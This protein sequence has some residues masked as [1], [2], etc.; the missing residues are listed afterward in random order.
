MSK[1]FGGARTY[2]GTQARSL[3]GLP[4][5]S[6]ARLLLERLGT[7]DPATPRQAAALERFGVVASPRG[8]SYRAASEL[9]T[10]LCGRID[11]QKCSLKQLGWLVRL[12]IPQHEARELSFGDASR[13]LLEGRS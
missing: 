7:T 4:E 5:P 13:L 11:E 6:E 9:L 2:T 3:L 10:V 1:I 12:G 8:F